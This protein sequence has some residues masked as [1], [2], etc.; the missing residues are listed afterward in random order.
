M[1]IQ[2]KPSYPYGVFREDQKESILKDCAEDKEELIYCK[3]SEWGY[4]DTVT[5]NKS[6]DALI[7][8]LTDA[9][10]CLEISTK[11]FTNSTLEQVIE[12]LINIRKE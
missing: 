8:R 2:W 5:Y 7:I 9:D 4:C 11:D 1:K 10:N 3:R 6:E 12:I